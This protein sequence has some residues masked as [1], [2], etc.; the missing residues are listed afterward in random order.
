[1][2]KNENGD[3]KEG[4]GIFIE[5]GEWRVVWVCKGKIEEVIFM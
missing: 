3:L 5:V 4:M 1:M 2:V